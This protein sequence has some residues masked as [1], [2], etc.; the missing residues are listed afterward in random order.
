MESMVLVGAGYWDGAP[1]GVATR[2]LYHLSP[3]SGEWSSV[4]GGLPENVEVR[5][6]AV[7][8]STLFAGTQ[9]GPC[10]STDVG[11][12]WTLMA[13]PGTERVVWSIMPVGEATLYVGTQ[14]T[15][16]Y[17]SD[18]DGETWR[19]LSVPT[20]GGMVR[21]GFPTR[22]IRL[23]HDPA[24]E[25]E[26]YAGLE[27][28]GVVRSLDGGETW[29]DCSAHLIELSQQDHLRS[30]IGSDTDAE[31][32]LDSHALVVSAARPGT[33]I[34]ANRMGLFRSADKGDHWSPIDIARYSELTYARDLKVSPHDPNTL[35]AAFSISADSLRGSLYRSQDLG[36]SWTRFDHGVS[37]ES[38]LMTIAASN[39]TPDRVYCAARRGQVFGTEDGGESWREFPLPDGVQGIYA[40]ACA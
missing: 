37:I 4:T 3:E 35:L 21:M 38:T 16:I 14:G 39:E 33:V 22:V 13:L 9:F 29:T 30:R 10:R 24:N 36:E 11:R 2:G 7:R 34:L 23:A 28:G 15:S 1:D 27:V 25:Q 17:K 19:L 40:L 32:M 18:D 6:M 31:G 20:P 12:S 26:I 5:G 8:G